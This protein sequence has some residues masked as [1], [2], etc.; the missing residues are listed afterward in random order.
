M[1]ERLNDTFEHAPKPNATTKTITALGLS[2]AGVYALSRT[3]IGQ[4]ILLFSTVPENSLKG[5]PPTVSGAATP[6]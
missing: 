4:L 6:G 5:I 1:W 2:A 3:W